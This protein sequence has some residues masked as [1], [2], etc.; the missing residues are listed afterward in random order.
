M[1]FQSEGEQSGDCSSPMPSSSQVQSSS[2]MQISSTR[3]IKRSPSSQSD[4]SLTRA[5]HYEPPDES[6]NESCSEKPSAPHSYDEYEHFGL[7]IASKIRKID[8]FEERET[9]MNVIQNIVY[10][11]VMRARGAAD[12]PTKHEAPA[13]TSGEPGGEEFLDVKTDIATISRCQ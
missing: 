3:T 2:Q 6:A 13:E 10:Q 8:N 5:I 11:S 12:Q 7:M 9:V 4:R 1:I